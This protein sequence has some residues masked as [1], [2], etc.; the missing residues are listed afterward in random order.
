M[1]TLI[2]LFIGVI[3]K[4]NFISCYGN[5]GSNLV[6]RVVAFLSFFVISDWIFVGSFFDNINPIL[7]KSNIKRVNSENFLIFDCQ[8][9][10]NHNSD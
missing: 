2:Y 8:L 6:H 3:I 1:Y 5:S 7:I 9:R 4:L 10:K